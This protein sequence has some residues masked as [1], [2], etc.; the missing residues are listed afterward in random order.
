MLDPDGLEVAM[1]TRSFSR[2][3]RDL[4]FSASRSATL[5]VRLTGRPDTASELRLEKRAL[6]AAVQLTPVLPVWPD[7]SVA[8]KVR[9]VDPSGRTNPASIKP[10]IRVTVGNR[11]V[12][13]SWSLDGGVWRAKIHGQTL[14][15]PQ[16]LRIEVDDENGVRLGENFVELV[17]DAR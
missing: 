2:A 10:R 4:N 5:R 13:T 6:R 8:A 12:P 14:P 16:V 7:D 15:G 1:Q 9:L 3:R 17:A 11:A